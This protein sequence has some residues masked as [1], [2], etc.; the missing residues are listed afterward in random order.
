MSLAVVRSDVRSYGSA[1]PTWIGASPSP[2]VVGRAELYLAGL[3]RHRANPGLGSGLDPLPKPSPIA[4]YR[5]GSPT[6]YNR[7]KPLLR[8]AI[9]PIQ[10]LYP[11]S[12]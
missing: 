2:T 9:R 1:P 5:R 3:G 4:R 6:P 10:P 12:S 11:S 8:L 7:L